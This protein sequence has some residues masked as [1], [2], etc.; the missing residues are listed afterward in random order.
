MGIKVSVNS[1]PTT[2]VSINNQVRETIRTAT[3]GAPIVNNVF[4]SDIK[5]VMA[6]NP[7]NND[8][9]VYDAN[10]QKYVVK[11]LPVADG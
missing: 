3:V 8:V 6:V 1:V 5:D 7:A 2:R 10:L 4:L 9:L 11:T